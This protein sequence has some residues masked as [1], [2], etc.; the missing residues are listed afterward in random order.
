MRLAQLLPMW[1]LAGWACTAAWAQ[2]SV[3][4]SSAAP[5]PAAHGWLDPA[6]P[7][8]PLLH[9]ALPP[10]AAV[11]DVVQDWRAANAAVAEFPRGHADVLRWEAAQQGRASMAAPQ[12]KGHP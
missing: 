3:P 10:G 8:R 7:V 4:P 9:L 2:T 11:V 5:A 1:G 12:H 6:A